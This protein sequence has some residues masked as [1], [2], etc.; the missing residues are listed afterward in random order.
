[1]FEKVH[2]TISPKWQKIAPNK[3]AKKWRKIAPNKIAKKWRNFVH[4]SRTEGSANV[5]KNGLRTGTHARHFFRVARWFIFKPKIPIWVK[6]WRALAWKTLLYFMTIW[7]I[8]WS[9]GIIYG[10]LV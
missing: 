9:F 5:L 8:F 7:N 6:I 4:S 2:P 3:I 1:M 10:C